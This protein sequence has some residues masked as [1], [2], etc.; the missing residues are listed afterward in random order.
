MNLKK[1]T[2][3]QLI[4]RF[5]IYKNKYPFFILIISYVYS[6]YS[7]FSYYFEFGIKDK[8]VFF[9]IP[10]MGKTFPDLRSITYSS[11]C[12]YSIDLLRSSFNCDPYRRPFNYPRL[13][14]DIFRK[15]NLEIDQT[16]L[17]GLIFGLIFIISLTFLIFN[18]ID[19]YKLKFLISSLSII[20]FP[21]QLVIERGNYDSIIFVMMIL[22][23]FL[24]KFKEKDSN[25]LNICLGIF[26]SILC[27]SLKIFPVA[28]LLAWRIFILSKRKSNLNFF[29]ESLFIIIFCLT[30]YITLNFNN[31][32]L[33]LKN[34]P[35]PIGF[36]SFGFMNL[37]QT[38]GTNIVLTFFLFIKVFLILYFSI[39]TFK[40]ILNNQF[41]KDD[42]LKLIDK[43]NLN[44]FI[45]FSFQ[46]L[47]LYFLFSSYDYRLIF[48]LGIIPF[49]ANYWFIIPK[50]IS[51]IEKKYFTYIALIIGFQ[52]YLR[53]PIYYISSYL[54]DLILQP[55]LIGLLIGYLFFIYQKI[56]LNTSEITLK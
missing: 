20:S 6:L 12:G 39:L 9:S 41:K 7:L 43:N 21:V 53:G 50:K 27:I 24:I 4:N 5:L 52:Q 37:Y 32:Y 34:T 33:I 38:Q 25:I 30:T 26:I 14:L 10:K 45:L 19:D 55:I 1:F 35:K 44:L 46:I 28:G 29:K 31:I 16:N 49:L 3:L 40:S 54:S 36:L 56:N 18:L 11:E 23:P 8:F 48:L 17:I 22:I 42:N 51:F 47:A 2:K 15:F 13:I